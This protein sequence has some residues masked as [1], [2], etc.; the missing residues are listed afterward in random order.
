MRS[1]GQRNRCWNRCPGWPCLPHIISPGCPDSLHTPFPCPETDPEAED[2]CKV[3][4]TLSVFTCAALASVERVCAKGEYYLTSTAVT[5]SLLY[6]NPKYEPIHKSSGLEPCRIYFSNYTFN[7]HRRSGEGRDFLIL[8][9]I[10][11]MLR[12]Y[13]MGRLNSKKESREI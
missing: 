7:N 2:P 8:S 11:G 12:V 4:F 1:F 3:S 5:R 10:S 9:L 13:D 6:A